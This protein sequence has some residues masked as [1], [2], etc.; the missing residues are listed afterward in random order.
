M[1]IAAT[2]NAASHQD[3][4]ERHL[5]HYSDVL[6]RARLLA[7]D[8][9]RAFGFVRPTADR[10][11][12]H[13]RQGQVRTA[14][15]VRTAIAMVNARACADA[16]PRS[17]S[18]GFRGQASRQEVPP[19][20]ARPACKYNPQ[21][22]A[23]QRQQRLSMSDLT[24]Q[25]AAPRSSA[26]RIAISRCRVAPRARRRRLATLLQAISNITEP[27]AISAVSACL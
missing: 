13:A 21:C 17:E 10:H 23:G 16:T 12:L 20:G 26:M 1:K 11:A 6:P 19:A 22:R 8:T 15:P 27:I 14:D 3:Q 9:P 7:F 25:T 24:N 18:A 2:E 5:D 4:R